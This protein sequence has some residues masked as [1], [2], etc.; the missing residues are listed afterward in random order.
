M[1][2]ANKQNIII[3]PRGP[4][5]PFQFL[6]AYGTILLWTLL[7]AFQNDG[8]NTILVVVYRL[9]KYAHFLLLKHLY[10]AISI[11]SV[12]LKEVV[13]LHGLLQRIVSEI[14]FLL[15]SFGRSCSVKTST[16]YHPQTDGQTQ[17]VNW[18]HKVYLHC[19]TNDHTK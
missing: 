2:Y 8:Y 10:T 11:A 5:Q 3:S 19:F 13:R 7:R 4:L 18:R 6:S 12:F 17:V 16:A 15:V 1:R 9:S 14:K